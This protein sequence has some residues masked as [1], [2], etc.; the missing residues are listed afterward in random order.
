MAQP[1]TFEDFAI[2]ETEDGYV[3]TL[4]AV[5]GETLT[6]ALTPEDMADILEALNDVLG[7]DEDD[8]EEDG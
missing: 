6:V 1:K 2:V 5:G 4:A 3:V 7:D 8:E